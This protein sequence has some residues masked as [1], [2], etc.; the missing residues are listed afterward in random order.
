MDRLNF[1]QNTNGFKLEAEKV[2]GQMHP[3]F[4]ESITLKKNS[5]V[6]EKSK[7]ILIKPLMW[8]FPYSS[9]LLPFQRQSGLRKYV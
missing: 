3:Y 1:S 9:V 7:H 6:F 5:T 4:A 2:V 8:E